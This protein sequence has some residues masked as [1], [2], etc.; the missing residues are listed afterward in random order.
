MRNRK[1]VWVVFLMVAVLCIGAGFAVVSDTLDIL[2]TANVSDSSVSQEFMKDVYFKKAELGNV[3]NED[4]NAPEDSISIDPN[5][6]DKAYFS[7]KSLGD[8]NDS[9]E[10]IYTIANDNQIPVYV[11]PNLKT[12]FASEFFDI[13]SDW[14]GAEKTIP[15][16]GTVTYT[17]TV[18]L[19]EQ[20]TSEVTA[21]AAVELKASSD[22][23]PVPNP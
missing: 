21:S 22:P 23:H 20:P 16:N 17:L 13:H 1:M 4:E 19:K 5:D 18:T 11:K 6:N 12:E 3:T 8:K 15:A 2:G 14:G 9:V 7:A 10:F